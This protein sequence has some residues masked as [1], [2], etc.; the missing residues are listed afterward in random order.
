MDSVV[1][2]SLKDIQIIIVDD[3]SKGRSAEICDAYSHK[4]QRIVVIHQEENSTYKCNF[5]V[6]TS[7]ENFHKRTEIQL[8]PL[9][10]CLLNNEYQ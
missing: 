8:F 7:I 4:D 6:T 9:V 5:F 10:F 2:Q 1:P 3:G